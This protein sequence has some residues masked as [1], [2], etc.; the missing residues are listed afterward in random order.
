[1]ADRV[2]A[3]E[4][5]DGILGDIFATKT[6]EEWVPALEAERV[7]YSRVN[8]Y[9]EALSD[10]QVAHRGLVRELDHPTSGPIRVVGAPWLTTGERVS[11]TPP[12]L[13]G[14]HTGEVLQE[15]LGWDNARIK[16]FGNDETAD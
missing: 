7:P 16:T 6:I 14:Q 2:A 8:D 10:P 9:A 4:T 1:M 3:R 15:W 12:P 11:D 13:L 5:I